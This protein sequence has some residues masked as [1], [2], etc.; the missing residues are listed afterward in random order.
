MNHFKLGLLWIL[1]LVFLT[2]CSKSFT[3]EENIYLTASPAELFQ[4]PSGPQGGFGSK[5][6][7]IIDDPE[8]SDGKA[9]AF[10]RTG[11][12][13]RFR[14]NSLEP[15]TYTVGV[16]ARGDEF[17]GWPTLR[18]SV[19][20]TQ[21]FKDVTV[22]SKTYPEATEQLGDF[23]L[24]RGQLLE[25]VF[26]NDAY[27]GDEK[28]RNVYLDYL[29]LTPV[30]SEPAPAPNPVPN[31][32][33]APNPA[34]TP[35]PTDAL[36]LAIDVGAVR[37]QAIAPVGLGLNAIV[38]TSDLGP[39]SAGLGIKNL[40]YSPMDAYFDGAAAPKFKVGIQD[41]ANYL[42]Y[43]V[44]ETGHRIQSQD[45]DAFMQVA[46][47]IG[48]EPI[49][50]VYIHSAIYEGDLPHGDWNTIVQAAAD[51]VR[52]A[53]ITKKYNVKRWE[54][55]NEVD[56]NGWTAAQY[57]KMVKDMS[58]AMKAV[59]PTIEVSANGMTGKAW[60]DE[61]LPQIA[62]D[63]DFLVTHQY[64]WY[65]DYAEWSTNPYTV[66]GNIDDVVNARDQ[67]APGT[68]IVLTETSAL[69]TT[70]ATEAN[71]VWRALHNVEVQAMGYFKG[72]SQNYFWVSRWFGQEKA[73][74]TSAF[75]N[76]Y[77]PT[78]LGMSIK[79]MNEVAKNGGTLLDYV[80]EITADVRS[81]SFYN[82]E[83]GSLAVLFL[84]KSSEAQ[85]VKVS[86]KGYSGSL[87]NKGLSL[88]GSAPDAAEVSLTEVQ[89]VSATSDGFSVTLPKLSA[90]LFTFGD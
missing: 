73:D 89:S 71:S 88:S 64:S 50:D 31:P 14:L 11:E 45:F 22:Q 74:M 63:V 13:V 24:G 4:S 57:A 67:Y 48:A 19:K 42:S 9:I 76:K 46:T 39:A 37:P 44:D 7:T 83:K 25:V 15:G 27:E 6:I 30:G 85:S 77:E 78:P 56:L 17:Q 80:P 60:W 2:A 87:T 29:V 81:W 3:T 58:A 5:S 38:D 28:D 65:K 90:T 34:P 79:F 66:G 35:A 69:N 54:I 40:R 21:I 55:G 1:A 59:D 33:P 70:Q 61:L 41:P 84:N 82:K 47:S 32:E 26:T 75:N 10:Y 20:G 68:P 23:Q 36:N 8:T 49:M 43:A 53:N 52:Y 72:S 62:N 51:W 18:V 86:L 12:G 16:R